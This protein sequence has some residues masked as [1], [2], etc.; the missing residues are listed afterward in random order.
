VAQ[1]IVN[2]ILPAAGSDPSAAVAIDF[3]SMKTRLPAWDDFDAYLFD[4]DGTLLRSRDRTHYSSFA[5]SLWTI[6]GLQGS[7]DGIPLHGNTDTAILQEVLRRHAIAAADAETLTPQILDAMRRIVL[8]R[9]HSIVVYP[10]PGVFATLE[11]L[12]RRD[13]LLGL[14]TGNLESIGWLKTEICGL[15]DYFTFGAFSD[16]FHVRSELIA[17]GAEQARALAGAQARIC[18]VGDTPADI[19]AAQANSLPVIAVATGM[20]SLEELGQHAP[21]FAVSTLR[22]LMACATSAEP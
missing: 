17:N 13:R 16:H 22:E 5:E 11:H 10:M 2:D 8:A 9:K 19:A 21:E 20:Y 1:T 7:L 15:R 12:R 6:T 18:V 3:K 4:I 14:G